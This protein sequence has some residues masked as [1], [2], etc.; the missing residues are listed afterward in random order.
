MGGYSGGN[1][2]RRAAWLNELLLS[3]E[4]GCYNLYWNDARGSEGASPT[5]CEG[6]EN[7]SRNLFTVLG[8]CELGHLGSSRPQA[9]MMR[10]LG[11][12]VRGQV[13]SCIW[14]AV[15]ALSWA[16]RPPC[17]L[18]SC[19]GFCLARNCDWLLSIDIKLCIGHQYLQEPQHGQ[20]N[21]PKIGFLCTKLGTARAQPD[22][23]THPALLKRGGGQKSCSPRRALGSSFMTVIFEEAHQKHVMQMFILDVDP[24]WLPRNEAA[25]FL[26]QGKKSRWWMFPTFPGIGPLI[27]TS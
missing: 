20:G 23:W 7:C 26:H 15:G 13:L 9:D 22:R 19:V 17:A 16:P 5:G 1:A 11:R 24:Q 14:A 2:W 8:S 12:D 4:G 21:Q 3:L 6:S 18:G 25:A 10:L 27:I